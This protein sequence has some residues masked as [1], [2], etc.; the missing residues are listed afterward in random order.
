MKLDKVEIY[1]PTLARLAEDM[2]KISLMV[3]FA[4]EQLFLIH[5]NMQEAETKEDPV[6]TPYQIAALLE[7]VGVQVRDKADWM[8]SVLE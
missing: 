8:E 3:S 2:G 4:H 6:M 5:E 1:K 7:M